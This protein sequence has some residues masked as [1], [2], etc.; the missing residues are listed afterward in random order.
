V[1]LITLIKGKVIG[2]A[3]NASPDL[4]IDEALSFAGV[5]LQG[6]TLGK[7]TDVPE[8]FC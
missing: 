2:N 6:S 4:T 3:I 1:L 5:K 8:I 7:Q